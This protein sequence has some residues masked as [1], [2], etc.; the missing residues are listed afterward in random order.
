MPR[1]RGCIL[2]FAIHCR[3]ASLSLG[4]VIA[5]QFIAIL[6]VH[7]QTPG[8]LRLASVAPVRARESSTGM[9]ELRSVCGRPLPLAICEFYP[10]ADASSASPRPHTS[11]TSLRGCTPEALHCAGRGTASERTV[12]RQNCQSRVCCSAPARRQ[13]AAAARCCC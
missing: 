3:F 5:L 9:R 8:V 11:V 6:L 2:Q 1:A 7:A 12:S 4:F 10:S 13:E